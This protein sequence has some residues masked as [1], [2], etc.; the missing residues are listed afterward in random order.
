MT[1]ACGRAAATR[2]VAEA[3]RTQDIPRSISSPRRVHNPRRSGEQTVANRS[4]CRAALHFQEWAAIRAAAQCAATGDKRRRG[5]RRGTPLAAR[6]RRGGRKMAYR[7]RGCGCRRCLGRAGGN[8][9]G[10]ATAG[11]PQEGGTDRGGATAGGDA[12]TVL[13]AP[14]IGTAAVPGGMHVRADRDTSPARTARGGTGS[15][16]CV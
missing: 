10:A 8:T 5:D 15:C 11:A 4:E 3:A 1:V 13:P 16:G 6:G 7:G 9:G 14:A 2:T 12:T